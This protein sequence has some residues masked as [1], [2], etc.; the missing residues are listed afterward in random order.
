VLNPMIGEQ[1]T[2]WAWELCARARLLL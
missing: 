2:C 1:Y